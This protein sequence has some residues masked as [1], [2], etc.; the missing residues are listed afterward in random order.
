METWGVE[1]G[2]YMQTLHFVFAIGGIVS[3]LATAPFLSASEYNMTIAE[4]NSTE[5][6]LYLKNESNR[7]LN[8]S[9]SSFVK[10]NRTFNM[11]Y[12]TSRIHGAFAISG[13]L[14]LSAAASFAYFVFI[15]SKRNNIEDAKAPRLQRNSARLIRMISISILCCTF[16]SYLVIEKAMVFFLST[17]TI[18]HLKWTTKRG[19]YVTT[20]YWTAFAIGRLIGIG[21]TK[22]FPTKRILMLYISMLMLSSIG[23]MLTN[24]FRFDV[25]IWIFVPLSGFSQSI[26]FP[27]LLSWIEEDFFKVSGKMISLLLFVGSIGTMITPII[28]GYL[29]DLYSPMWFPYSQVI[30]SVFL[31]SFFVVLLM[32]SGKFQNNVNE[33]E[34]FVESPR[35]AFANKGIK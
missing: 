2:P 27:L 29:I 4:G 23:L 8:L 19:S 7:N 1:N 14:V 18:E 22:R 21:I 16:L 6:I 10:L 3:P 35:E 30:A 33:I 31:L 15:M 12:Q 9:T 34:L 26:L 25:G 28:L 5:Y 24:L 17:F 20:I 32:L 11:E 13:V